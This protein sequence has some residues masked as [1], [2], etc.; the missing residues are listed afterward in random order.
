MVN[1]QDL[2]EALADLHQR[3]LNGVAVTVEQVAKEWDVP[4][5]AV[6]ARFE[7]QFGCKPEDFVAPE[8][9]KF[10]RVGEALAKERARWRLTSAGEALW[11][12]R[13]YHQGEWWRMIAWDG[14]KLHAFREETLKPWYFTGPQTGKILNA[15]K[16]A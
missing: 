3:L 6:E 5:R 12:R 9:T 7:K 4:A 11:G 15:V 14:S 16:A 13:F 10:D 2:S 1:Q 8:I